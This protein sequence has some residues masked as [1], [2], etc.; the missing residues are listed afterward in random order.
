VLVV[1]PTALAQE[2]DRPLHAWLTIH[3]ALAPGR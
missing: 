3:R 2:M 1:P